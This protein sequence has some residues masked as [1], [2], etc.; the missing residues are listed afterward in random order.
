MDVTRTSKNFATIAIISVALLLAG[1]CTWF[2]KKDTS[3]TIGALNFTP[4]CG[5]QKNNE[6]FYML[7]EYDT[8]GCPASVKNDP[9]TGN[10][11]VEQPPDTDKEPVCLCVSKNVRLGWRATNLPLGASYAVYFSPFDRDGKYESDAGGEIKPEKIKAVPATAGSSNKITYHYTLADTTDG[12][13]NC[14]PLDPPI[15]VDQ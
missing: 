10:G 8:Q 15:I 3:G 6:R 9:A 1:G 11:C 12:G 5:K 7:V 13:G 14:D 2:G 4:D